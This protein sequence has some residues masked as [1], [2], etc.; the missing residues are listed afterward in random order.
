MRRKK[1][2]KKKRKDRR[3]KGQRTQ[4]EKQRWI[5]LTSERIQ[6]RREILASSLIQ[7]VDTKSSSRSPLLKSSLSEEVRS[8]VLITL[9]ITRA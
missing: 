5:F 8:R 6:R 1:R 2:M 9:N 4:M 3:K 7:S